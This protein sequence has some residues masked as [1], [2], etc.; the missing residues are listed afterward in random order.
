MSVWRDEIFG[1]VT[2]I[3]SFRDEA[4]AV[5]LAND[6]HYGLAAS[7]WTNDLGRAHRVADA[8]DVGIAWINDHHRIDPSSPWSGRKDSGIG[9]ENGLD[10]YRAYTVP[11]SIIINTSDQHSDWFGSD[12]DTRYS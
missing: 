11:K 10:G 9:Q 2:V 6:A 5:S 3:K 8:L 12:E 1:P 4:E 7:V